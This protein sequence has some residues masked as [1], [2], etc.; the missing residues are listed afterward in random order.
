MIDGAGGQ[1]L[2]A[3]DMKQLRMRKPILPTTKEVIIA[4][5]NF[6]QAIFDKRICHKGQESLKNVVSNCEKRPIG[7]N[8]GFGYKA[9]KEG[10]EIALLDSIMLAL[11]ASDTAKEAKPQRISY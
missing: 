7:S 6:E 11:W 8:G 2:L 10:Y 3:G 9:L 1:Q 4:N 5:A